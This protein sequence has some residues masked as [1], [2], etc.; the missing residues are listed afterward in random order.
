MSLS[1]LLHDLLGDLDTTGVLSNNVAALAPVA[2]FTA[3]TDTH[4]I[5]DAFANPPLTKFI[6][7]GVRS[8]TTLS[9]TFVAT[10]TVTN[11]MGS[12]GSQFTLASGDKI[13]ITISGNFTGIDTAG[14]TYA[15]GTDLGAGPTGSFTISSDLN[16]ATTSINGNVFNGRIDISM[17]KTDA[18]VLAN[19]VFGV[20]A[21][22]APALSTTLNRTL[23]AANTAWWQWTSNGTTYVVPYITYNPGGNSTK[24]RFA[25]SSLSEVTVS[26]AVVLDSGV[27]ATTGTTSFTIPAQGSLQVTFSDTPVTPEQGPVVTNLSPTDR[28]VRAKATFTLLTDPSN[29]AGLVMISSPLGVVSVYQMIQK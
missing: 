12:A 10:N 21:T 6:L 11:V 28:T 23:G 2:Q 9:S 19:R 5:I 1:V 24:F 14:V 25:N 15:L 27:T 7:S 20:S 17:T 8:N 22:I 13:T 16:L 18:S 4:T 26:V 29:V 3:G